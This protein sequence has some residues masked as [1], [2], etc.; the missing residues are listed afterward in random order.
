MRIYAGSIILVVGTA[1]IGSIGLRILALMIRLHILIDIAN[2]APWRMPKEFFSVS[3]SVIGYLFIMRIVDRVY[4]YNMSLLNLKLCEYGYEESDDIETAR[5]KF[6]QI[7][8]LAMKYLAILR[9]MARCHKSVVSV[10]EYIQRERR[11]I[12]ECTALMRKERGM[13]EAKRWMNVP[14]MNLNNNKPKVLVTQKKVHFVRRIRSY[15]F[16]EILVS[17]IMYVYKIQMLK[18]RY[19]E[20]IEAFGEIRRFVEFLNGYKGEYLLLGDLDAMIRLGMKGLKNEVFEVEKLI[21]TRLPSD[22]FVKD[23]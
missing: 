23:Y 18:T 10:G 12:L 5:F 19:N 6:F 16:I 2:V 14:Q 21:A 9:R 4:I 11:E 22:V 13:M 8:G 20:A 1:I 7:S 3:V 17:R 15:N